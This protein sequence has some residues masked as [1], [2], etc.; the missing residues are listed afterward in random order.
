[1]WVLPARF[2]DP[3]RRQRAVER[4]AEEGAGFCCPWPVQCARS[5]FALGTGTLSSCSW[6]RRAA[7]ARAR[8]RGC[9]KLQSTFADA[10]AG[11]LPWH[12]PASVILPL[13][14]DETKK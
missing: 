8:S 12:K 1:M 4:L 9:G 13:T 11:M 14:G 2:A 5:S 6:P 3:S 10:V 7:A